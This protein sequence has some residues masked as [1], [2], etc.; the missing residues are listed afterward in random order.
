MKLLSVFVS[1]LVVSTWISIACADLTDGLVLYM[2]LDEGA[3]N[4]VKDASPNKFEGELNGNAKWV[5]GK[6]GKALQFAAS[7]DFVSI[8]DDEVFHISETISQA[9]WI[10]LDRLPSAHAIIFGTRNGAGGRNIGFGYGMDPDNNIKVWT[11]NPGGSFLDI[12][13]TTTKLETGKWYYLAYT[14]QTDNGGLVEIYVD[15]ELT[16]S[17]ASSNPVEPAGVPNE[18]I[19]GTWGTEAWP[20]IVDEVRM[21]N[22][23]LTA[24]EIKESMNKGALEI[25]LVQPAGRLATRWGEI[26]TGL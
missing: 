6:F 9:A 14:H 19:I 13:D 23:I 24:D 10:N 4:T 7:S 15:G 20:G 17:Q 21:W 12:D 16:H 5:D 8:A 3:G 25:V 26:K 1:I 11:N 22:R 2:S 18:V